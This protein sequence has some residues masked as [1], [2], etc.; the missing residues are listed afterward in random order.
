MGQHP[1]QNPP[2]LRCKGDFGECPNPARRGRLCWGHLKLRQKGR[3]V[4]VPLREP[5]G[6]PRDRAGLPRRSM[7]R[8]LLDA[9][10]HIAG[11]EADQK[12]DEEWERAKRRL[13]MASLRHG[14][15]SPEPHP[16]KA[17]DS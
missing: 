15:T 1:S 2:P 9:S 17:S 10:L 6:A 3:S 5:Q 11:L 7:F 8:Q 12:G 4:D 14:R 13:S 16:R